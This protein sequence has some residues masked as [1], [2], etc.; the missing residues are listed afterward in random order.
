M[1]KKSENRYGMMERRRTNAHG[2]IATK[3]SIGSVWEMHAGS[4]KGVAEHAHS[5]CLMGVD[6]PDMV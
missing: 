3:R 5:G 4:T 1:F 2:I 6:V